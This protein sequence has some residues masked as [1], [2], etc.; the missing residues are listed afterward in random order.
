MG[1]PYAEVDALPVTVYEV[2][3][4]MLTREQREREHE[5]D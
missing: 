3:V 5:D 4:A 1:W 2:L